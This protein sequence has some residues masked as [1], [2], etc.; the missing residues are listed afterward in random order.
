MSIFPT[1]I[2]LATDGSEEATLAAQTAIDLANK[3]GSELHVVYADMLP[4]SP[5]LY[6]GYQAGVDAGAYLQDESEEFT[7]RTGPTRRAGKEDQSRW[8]QCRTSS[9][10]NR[11]A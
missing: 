11:K 4:Y 2:L 3:T 8:R 5:A 1:R 9:F 7:H 10:Q 6:E